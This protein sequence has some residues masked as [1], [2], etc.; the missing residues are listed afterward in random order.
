MAPA[1]QF[2]PADRVHQLPEYVR[3]PRTGSYRSL[4]PTTKLVVG[5]VEVAAAFILGHWIGPLL[6]LAVLAV[7]ACIAQ[8]A[9][10]L[11]IVASLTFPV[12]GS[13]VVINTFLLPG[14]HDP[15]VRLGPLAPTWSGLAFGTEVTLRLLAI[16]LALALV[17]LTTPTDDLLSDL[18]RRG[19]G[20][21]LIFVVGAAVNM[22]PRTI[23]RAAEIID[24]QRAR[25]LDTEGRFWRRARG[26]IPLAGP[27]IFGALTEVE[28]QTMA[29][30]ARAFSAPVRRTVLRTL[31]DSGRQRTVRWV[32]FL[33]TLAAVAA[34]IAGVLH[35]P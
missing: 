3:R 12:V 26:V 35:L 34:E 2:G 5:V 19:V 29:L 8:V 1:T 25:A 21:R 4:N 33:G 24:A 20:R 13:I 22:V 18:E 15:I 11:A 10:Q 14:A 17:Y 9:R 32:L 30:E 23:E 28:E 7:A 16:S 31:P 6:V 27:M